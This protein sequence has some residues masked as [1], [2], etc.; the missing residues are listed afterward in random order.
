[1]G[2]RKQLVKPPHGVPAW[3]RMGL[4]Y[5]VM[6]Q[7]GRSPASYKRKEALRSVLVALFDHVE[8]R[9]AQPHGMTHVKML[10]R[11]YIW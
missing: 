11:W 8:I 4:A 10:M 5:S 2:N 3:N 1:M 6:S 7:R 9:R